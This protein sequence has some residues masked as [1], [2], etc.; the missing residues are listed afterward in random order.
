MATSNLHDPSLDEM[1][2][3]IKREKE[4]G[5]FNKGDVSP[6]YHSRKSV[7]ACG[8][9]VPIWCGKLRL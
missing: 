9:Q 8:K 5:M 6:K 2:E 1:K 3:K 4:T 7:R